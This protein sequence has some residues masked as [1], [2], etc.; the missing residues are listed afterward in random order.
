[1]S[2][3]YVNS[4]AGQE[5]QSQSQSQQQQQPSAGPSSSG[6]GGSAG[7]GGGVGGGEQMPQLMCATE[8]TNLLLEFAFSVFVNKPADIVEYAAR[9]FNQLQSQRSSPAAQLQQQHNN[10][11]NSSSK[12]RAASGRPA[13][14]R[15]Q[16]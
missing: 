9:Y 8:L 1:M 11:N 10:N 15:G 13:T 4:Q 6:S 5:Q 2:Q 14:V 3:S 16:T 7:A 12:P